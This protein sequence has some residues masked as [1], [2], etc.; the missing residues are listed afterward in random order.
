MGD[1]TFLHTSTAPTSEL[2]DLEMLTIPHT[3]LNSIQLQSHP[4]VTLLDMMSRLLRNL[5][6]A[7]F[8]DCGDCCT[9]YKCVLCLPSPFLFFSYPT[10]LKL[11]AWTK[12]FALSVILASFPVAIEHATPPSLPAIPT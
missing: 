11:S 10:N 6:R 4:F 2:L 5:S 8:L 1:M 3:L 7:R 12:Y 9:W